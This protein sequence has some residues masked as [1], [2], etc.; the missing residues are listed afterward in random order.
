M[1]LMRAVHTKKITTVNTSLT[2]IDMEVLQLKS[3]LL[4][5]ETSSDSQ[6][7]HDDFSTI[8]GENLKPLFMEHECCFYRYVVLFSVVVSHQFIYNIKPHFVPKFQRCTHIHIYLQVSIS[9]HG[10]ANF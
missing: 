4:S 3:A 1:L 7:T 2:Q 9:I 10:V 6:P 5:E 8:G